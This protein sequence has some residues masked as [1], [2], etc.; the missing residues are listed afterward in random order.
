[1]RSPARRPLPLALALARIEEA[2]RALPRQPPLRP[3]ALRPAAARHLAGAPK[4]HEI[5]HRSRMSA[6]G[7]ARPCIWPGSGIS[8]IC[9]EQGGFFFRKSVKQSKAKAEP[10]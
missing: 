4:P 5:T 3:D 1:M 2:R 7:S 9:R 6:F 8:S 10:S